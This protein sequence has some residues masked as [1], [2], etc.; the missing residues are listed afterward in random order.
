ML[1][2]QLLLIKKSNVFSRTFSIEEGVG[3]GVSN[4]LDTINTYFNVWLIYTIIHMVNDQLVKCK[5]HIVDTITVQQIKNFKCKTTL[6]HF[7]SS[8]SST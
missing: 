5:M 6:S 8:L 3:K 4:I 1:F 7:K 2:L